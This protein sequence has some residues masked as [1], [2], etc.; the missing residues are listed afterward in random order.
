MNDYSSKEELISKRLSE[1]LDA[2]CSIAEKKREL[3]S[4][5][6]FVLRSEQELL[7]KVPA[8]KESSILFL[9]STGQPCCAFFTENSLEIRTLSDPKEF[10]S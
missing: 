10:N 3:D 8:I 7:A 5:E 1:V 9:S 6:N 2:L 4:L